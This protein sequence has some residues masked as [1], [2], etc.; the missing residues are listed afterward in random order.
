[1]TEGKNEWGRTEEE[2]GR[3]T[4]GGGKRGER[5]RIGVVMKGPACICLSG[6]V[7][8]S[9]L[10]PVH[11]PPPTNLQVFH[12]LGQKSWKALCFD[13]CFGGNHQELKLTV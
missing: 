1:M 13:L 4:N 5:E 12:N 10:K 3:N 11:P 9:W 7:S 6:D 2:N 8:S